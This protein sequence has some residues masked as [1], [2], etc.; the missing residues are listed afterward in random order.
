MGVR[1]RLMQYGKAQATPFPWNHCRDRLPDRRGG[2]RMVRKNAAK[3]KSHVRAP[4][5]LFW[6]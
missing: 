6:L 4:A 2:S 1:S 3:E 5:A